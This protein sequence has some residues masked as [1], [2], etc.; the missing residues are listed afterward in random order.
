MLNTKKDE[1]RELHQFRT[2][3]Q[4]TF[5]LMSMIS[6]LK[7]QVQ[8]TSWRLLYEAW[9]LK[10]AVWFTFTWTFTGG[11]PITTLSANDIGGHLNQ[12]SELILYTKY[13]YFSKAC[14]PYFSVTEFSAHM[15]WFTSR[16]T[17]RLIYLLF[18]AVLYYWTC[19]TGSLPYTYSTPRL[20]D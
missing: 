8:M 6:S 3:L 11:R 13:E 20:R 14:P 15:I 2:C 12:I 4:Y 19:Q 18:E 1:L 9:H 7:S 5:L 16:G 10:K 17:N